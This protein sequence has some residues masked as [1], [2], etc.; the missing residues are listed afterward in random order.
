MCEETKRVCREEHPVGAASMRGARRE[1]S[2][3]SSGR[4]AALKGT[5]GRAEQASAPPGL[6][7]C[8]PSGREWTK[9]TWHRLAQVKWA[10][11]PSDK[12]SAGLRRYSSAMSFRS[13]LGMVLLL[14][15][16]AVPALVRGSETS[17]GSLSANV[18]LQ[19][20]RV[21]VFSN[22]FG[23]LHY[24]NFL[25]IILGREAS[26]MG[27]SGGITL[28]GALSQTSF[29]SE[30]GNEFGIII[31]NYGSADCERG[32][33]WEQ[34]ETDLKELFRRLKATG[35]IVVYNQIFPES[36]YPFGRICE[37]EGALRVPEDY[38]INDLGDPEGV[39]RLGMPW[40]RSHPSFWGQLVLAE[41]TA[42]VMLDAGIVDWVEPCEMDSSDFAELYLAASQLIDQVQ[43]LDQASEGVD[44]DTEGILDYLAMAEPLY[45]KGAY[46]ATRWLLRDWIMEPLTITVERWDDILELSRLRERDFNQTTMDWQPRE[47]IKDPSHL[48]GAPIS[49][50]DNLSQETLP[51]RL[52]SIL[53]KWDEVKGMFAQAMECIETLKEQGDTRNEMICSATYSKAEQEWLEYDYDGTCSALNSIV[54][55]CPE[56][57]I[58]ILLRLILVPFLHARRRQL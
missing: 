36:E 18:T 23:G 39:E 21:M 52:D 48:G 20:D 44:V 9:T 51:Y 10:P 6:D 17:T 30:P 45:E 4:A 8:R 31:T 16:L 26:R 46:F 24:T 35:A 15:M 28:A 32:Y 58:A 41:R 27:Q 47:W 19:D 22:S 56:P 54:A 29:L 25:G 42:R 7:Q 33:P 37:E 3:Y 11:A 38:W 53:D 57:S 50:P 49:P 43:A 5:G 34:I 2:R 40:G 1:N 14:A 13:A 12:L 55:K